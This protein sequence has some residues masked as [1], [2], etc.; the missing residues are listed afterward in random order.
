[1]MEEWIEIDVIDNGTRRSIT[2]R[3]RDVKL[4]SSTPISGT[5]F[6]DDKVQ[7]CRKTYILDEPKDDLLSRLL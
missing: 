5:V 4:I 3:K 2:C 7:I 6:Q 1:M